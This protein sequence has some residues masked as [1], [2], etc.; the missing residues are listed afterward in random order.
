MSN[1]L[2][3]KGT[4]FIREYGEGVVEKDH[5]AFLSIKPYDAFN[6]DILDHDSRLFASCRPSAKFRCFLIH[7]DLFLGDFYFR[8]EEKEIIRIH[9]EGLLGR[10]RLLIHK[11]NEFTFPRNYK[12]VKLHD[13]IFSFQRRWNGSLAAT[14][15]NETYLDELI[16][17]SSYLWYRWDRI[18]SF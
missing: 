6:F 11:E 9:F 1:I 3:I 2:T 10:K 5:I 15:S 12:D 4:K 18:H 8:N 16:C 14:T 13:S 7:N 17:V